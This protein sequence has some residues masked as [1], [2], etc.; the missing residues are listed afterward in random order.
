MSADSIFKEIQATPND[1]SV[2]FQRY[3]HKTFRERKVF[4]KMTNYLYVLIY[5]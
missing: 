3:F 1:V 2:Y 5:N 4:V